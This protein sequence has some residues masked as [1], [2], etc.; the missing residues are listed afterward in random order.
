MGRGQAALCPESMQ[1]CRGA[2]RTMDKER[3]ES[4]L[5]GRKPSGSLW[6]TAGRP[7]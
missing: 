3:I 6:G 5:G 7:E 1:G 4:G 2:G